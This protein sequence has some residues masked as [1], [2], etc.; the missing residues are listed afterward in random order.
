MQCPM[1]DDQRTA[2]GILR[3]TSGARSRSNL[4]R[5]ACCGGTHDFAPLTRC[6]HLKCS[7]NQSA[8]RRRPPSSERA[9]EPRAVNEASEARMLESLVSRVSCLSLGT[10]NVSLCALPIIP[11]PT[12]PPNVSLPAAWETNSSSAG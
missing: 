2:L 9:N 3:A 1:A 4:S 8:Q 6:S 5:A 10:R 11:R 7:R 12:L